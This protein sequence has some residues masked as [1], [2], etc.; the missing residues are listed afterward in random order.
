MDKYTLRAFGYAAIVTIGGFVFGLD[1]AVISGTLRYITLE[2]GLTD[3]QVGTV[4]SAPALGVLIALVITG[5]ICDSIGRKKTLLL[6]AILYILSAVGS[7]WATSYEMLVGARFIG[8]LAFTSLSLASMYIG[9]IAP[10]AQR[11]KLVS[12]NQLMIVLGLTAAYFSNYWLVGLLESNTAWVIE[13]NLLQ[14]IWRWMLGVEIIPAVIWA[15][16]LLL[17]PLS[18]R[19]LVAKGRYDEAKVSL[20]KLMPA[21]KIDDELAAIIESSQQEHQKPMK[22]T[23][24]FQ[25]MFEKRFRLAIM[26]GVI[27]AA[28]QP[29]TGVNP[30]LFYAPMVFEQTGIGTNAAFAQTLIIGVV[31]FVFTALAI[32]LV[33]RL[34][35]RPL[36]N[37]GLI[38]SIVCLVLCVTAFKQAS[39]TLT[40]DDVVQIETT[41]DSDVAEQ[42]QPLVGQTFDSDTGYKNALI[43]AIGQDS[44]KAHES[45]LIQA[46]VSINAMLVLIGIVGFIAAFHVSIGPLMWVVFSEIVPTQ[47]RGVAIPGFALISSVISYFMQKFFPWQL[48]NFGAADIFT[49][50]AVAGLIGLVLL[51]RYLPE[52]KNKSIEEVERLLNPQTA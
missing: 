26:I 5:A 28:V 51:Y 20:A 13:Y 32:V 36:V 9:E 49:S 47:I 7:A 19:W 25:V 39:Y 18:P 50:Y 3:L 4:V 21:E 31:S 24:Q 22:L 2:F 30:I 14:D 10:P 34:G 48:A 52:T 11:G 8:G 1:A 45:E 37:F 15:L 41:L 43:A 12:M 44:Y 46:A 29:L 16:L 17:V 6:I 38:A 23:E 35:R 27:F 42:L 40:A 33:D